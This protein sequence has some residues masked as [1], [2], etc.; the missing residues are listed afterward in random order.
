[1]IS[2]SFYARVKKYLQRHWF[3]LFF[4][5]SFKHFG[6]RVAIISP[7]IIEGAEYISLENSVSINSKVWLL[8]LKQNTLT[9]NLTIKEGSALGRFAHIVAIEEVIIGKNVL[10]ADKV[11]ISDN[12]HDYNDITQPIMHQPVLFKGKVA[13]GDH[14]WIGENVSI[15][16]A[17]IGKHCVIGANSVV[18][19]DIPDYC[20]AVG[21]PAKVIKRYNL[22]TKT[23]ITND[24]K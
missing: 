9:P 6:K 16:G 22:Q 1:M 15:I 13:I 24:I 11:Y 8:A 10:I 17:S 18:T 5:H 2:F 19:H 21:T 12:L 20:V 14:S 4:S 23:W 7:D 3:A